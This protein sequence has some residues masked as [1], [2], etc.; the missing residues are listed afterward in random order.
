M[1]LSSTVKT[2]PPGLHRNIAVDTSKQVSYKIAR[3]FVEQ[4]YRRVHRAEIECDSPYL[5]AVLDGEKNV[6][7]VAGI[8]PPCETFFLEQYLHASAEEILCRLFNESVS[9]EKIVEVGSLAGGKDRLATAYL[10]HQMW[11]YLVKSG[12]EYLMLTGTRSVL[13]KFRHLPFHQLARAS[14]S[15]VYRPDS[16][17]TY[18]TKSPCVVTGRLADYDFRFFRSSR[19]A[20][21]QLVLLT[22]G[23]E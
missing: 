3:E 1:S 9:R 11:G 16:W 8:R 20:D 17:G 7:A 22:A 15:K 10:M 21:Y 5:M 6:A 14:R 23:D 19:I 18:Y 12:Y 13:H 4:Q 2:V